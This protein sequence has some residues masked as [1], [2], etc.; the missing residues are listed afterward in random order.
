M[1]PSAPAPG[2]TATADPRPASRAPRRVNRTNF[3]SLNYMRSRNRS[4]H[5]SNRGAEI[6][7]AG[8]CAN[9]PLGSAADRRALTQ[10]AVDDAGHRK[11]LALEALYPGAGLRMSAIA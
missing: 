2:A 8:K 11:K 5:I 1:A 10:G 3:M 9:A 6:A 4:V 7:A